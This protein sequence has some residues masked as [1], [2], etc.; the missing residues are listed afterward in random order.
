MKKAGNREF[1][2][3]VYSNFDHSFEC[4]EEY[5]KSHS[6]LFFQ[7]SAWN[8]CGYIWYEDEKFHEEVWVHN[9]HR[10][11]IEDENLEDLIEHVNDEYG[12][13]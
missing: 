7:H 2:G 10:E 6:N 5:V 11:T 3:I 1:E 8:F 12:Y 9:I 13:E 4:D